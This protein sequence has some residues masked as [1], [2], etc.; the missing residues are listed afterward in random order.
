MPGLRTLSALMLAQERRHVEALAAS[1][2]RR[3]PDRL[4]PAP[5][6]RPA[7]L[8]GREIGF[9][10][11]CCDRDARR[12]SLDRPRDRCPYRA[13]APLDRHRAF[14]LPESRRDDRDQDLAVERRI[15]DR[16]EDDVG[17]VAR[18]LDHDRRGLVHLVER[19]VA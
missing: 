14:A 1:E 6:G 15:D 17:V 10:L 4:L 7:Q 8:L 9:F 18:G 2:V 5:Y 13:R 16:A 19:E 3:T 12:T 11:G